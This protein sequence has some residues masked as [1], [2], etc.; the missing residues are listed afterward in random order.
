M[1]VKIRY[2][3]NGKDKILPDLTYMLKL[4]AATRTIHPHYDLKNFTQIVNQ[5]E[6]MKVDLNKE[7]EILDLYLQG[8]ECK[9]IIKLMINV[10]KNKVHSSEITLRFLCLTISEYIFEE[11]YKW[12]IHCLCVMETMFKCRDHRREQ[13]VYHHMKHIIWMILWVNIQYTYFVYGCDNLEHDLLH[14]N[15]R[16]K[17]QLNRMSI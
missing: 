9:D 3:K 11:A 5:T 13:D 16:I 10:M 2:K 14:K 4:D 6:L 8:R 15:V 7:T 17:R 12:R 1:G